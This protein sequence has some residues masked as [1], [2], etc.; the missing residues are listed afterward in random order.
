V[1][2]LAVAC[3]ETFYWADSDFTRTYWP[4]LLIV[5]GLIILLHIVFRPNRNTC[6]NYTN[7]SSYKKHHAKSKFFHNS[8]YERNS[9]FGNVEEIIL[10]PVFGGGEFN[11]IFG[12]ITLDLRKTSIVEGETAIDLNCVFGGITVYVPENWY[13]VSHT[14]SI[15]G[16]FED[17]R[18]TDK[19]I[20]YSR[21]LVVLGACVFG[22]VEIKN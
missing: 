18:N 12:G 19:E 13:V 3:P 5:A 14:D 1:P 10:D 8:G 16:G 4:M 20:D 17:S 6:N 11:A 15:F 9:V 7:T 22:G 2:R 21:K